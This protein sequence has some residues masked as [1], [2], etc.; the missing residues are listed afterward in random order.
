MSQLSKSV[1]FFK[2][3]KILFYSII[4]I[5]FSACIRRDRCPEYTPTLLSDKSSYKQYEPVNLKFMYSDRATCEWMIDG[6]KQQETGSELHL[7]TASLIRNGNVSCRAKMGLCETYA[8]LNLPISNETIPSCQISPNLIYLNGNAF[9]FSNGIYKKSAFLFSGNI[10]NSSD[11]IQIK[12]PTNF[13]EIYP[14]SLFS[15]FVSPN[16]VKVDI[17]ITIGGIV[18]GSDNNSYQILYTRE[19]NTASLLCCNLTLQSLSQP[20]TFLNANFNISILL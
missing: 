19:G 18:Y 3:K 5:N 16:K 1:I 15:V 20:T 17:M 10:A 6:V 4:L 13:D 8:S 12:M 7:K 14:I 2:M 9:S 11:K